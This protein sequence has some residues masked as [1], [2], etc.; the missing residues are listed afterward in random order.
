VVALTSQNPAACYR[1]SFT[2]FTYMFRP[3]LVIFRCLRN[4]WW[5]CYA[6]IHKFNC[7]DIP[8][9]IRPCV[10]WWWVVPLILSCVTV[11]NVFIVVIFCCCCS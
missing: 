10:L 5:N 7:W 1:D 3:T 8:S 2:Y 9:S 6:S 4:C 11:M